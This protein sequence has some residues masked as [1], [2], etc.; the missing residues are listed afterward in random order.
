LFERLDTSGDGQI[1]AGEVPADQRWLFDRLIRKGDAN[2]D[3]QLSADELQQ[4][5]APTTP[6]KPLT[7][8][9]TASTP[10]GNATRVLLLLMDTTPDGVIDRDEVPER[11]L[12]TF[13]S[14]AEQVD[15][16]KNNKIDTL[17]LA[18]GGPQLGRTAVRAVARMRIDVDRE[19][20]RLT[21]QQGE[22]V[23]RF[24]EPPSRERMFASPE[25]A[26]QL[27]ASLDA[28]GNG[29]LEASEVPEQG[30]GNL[31]RLFRAFDADGDKALSRR[32]FARAA[33]R[34]GQFTNPPAST[35]KPA[36]A[37]KPTR[38]SNKPGTEPATGKQPTEQQL[39]VAANLVAAIVRRLDKD[40]DGQLA[41]SEITGPMA[42]R[43]ERADLDGN[44]SI[45]TDELETMKQFIA[46]RLAS[47][48]VNA[49][50]LRNR[51]RGKDE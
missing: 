47:G 13:D 20:A 17:E 24:D 26:M 33:E 50:Q 16:N 42:S 31:D 23:K 49:Q 8:P 35:D 37:D 4:A 19:L 18:R 7:E 45:D 32:E 6:T 14:F 46:E 39:K 10:A 34:I 12:A 36:P 5:L 3:G 22:R 11:L 21:K 38:P 27:F 25:R 44:G 28:N 40:G 51:L 1:A 2:G 48:E 15:Y 43:I 41:A 9:P 29:K 30:A